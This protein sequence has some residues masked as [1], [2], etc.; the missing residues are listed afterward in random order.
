MTPNHP[1]GVTLDDYV[2][3]ALPAAERAAVD[4]ASDDLR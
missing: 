3:D 1:D 4:A 2:D